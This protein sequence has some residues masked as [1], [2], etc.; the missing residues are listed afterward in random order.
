MITGRGGLVVVEL[1]PPIFVL[2]T[3]GGGDLA[4][5]NSLEEAAGDFEPV[6]VVNHEY[7]VYDGLGRKLLVHLEGSWTR[8]SVGSNEPLRAELARRLIDF[9]DAVGRPVVVS[10]DDWVEF[11]RVAA[12]AVRQYR[13]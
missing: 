5:Y 11:T 6:D 3:N 12:E 9:C 10:P 4:V 2:S 8:T 13:A 7:D 1:V